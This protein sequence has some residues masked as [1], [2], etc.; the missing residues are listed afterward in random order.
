MSTVAESLEWEW[1]RWV[2]WMPVRGGMGEFEGAPLSAVR[3]SADTESSCRDM[4]ERMRETGMRVDGGRMLIRVGGLGVMVGGDWGKRCATRVMLLVM[5][6]RRNGIGGFLRCRW[7]GLRRMSL[8]WAI[9]R[10]MM[11]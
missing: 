8:R 5:C 3:V 11:R 6:V 1:E 4:R 9:K 2:V 10:S 7:N